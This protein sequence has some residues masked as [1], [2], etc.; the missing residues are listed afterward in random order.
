MDNEAIRIIGGL[1]RQLVDIA[2][3]QFSKGPAARAAQRPLHGFVPPPDPSREFGIIPPSLQLDIKAMSESLPTDAV[4]AVLYDDQ[5]AAFMLG[6]NAKV[7]ERE[8]RKGLAAIRK[9]RGMTQAKLA[10]L[11]GLAR[12]SIAYIETGKRKPTGETLKKLAVALHCSI[13]DLI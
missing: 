9:R 13:D 6:Y 7:K 12:E 8:E 10:E 2:P 11:T 5:Q 3:D 1:Y 4:N